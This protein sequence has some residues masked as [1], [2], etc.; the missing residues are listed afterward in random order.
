[1]H[2]KEEECLRTGGSRCLQS[3]AD[4]TAAPEVRCRVTLLCEAS[5]GLHGQALSCSCLQPPPTG[6]SELSAQRGGKVLS[7]GDWATISH[8]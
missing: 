5:P 7:L 2:W 3:D 4:I 1:M 6:P 8:S